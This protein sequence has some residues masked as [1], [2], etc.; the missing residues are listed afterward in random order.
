M[1][2]KQYQQFSP[3]YLSV[4]RAFQSMLSVGRMLLN[5]CMLLNTLLKELVP[6][7]EDK[8]ENAHSADHP[9]TCIKF[10]GRFIPYS[11]KVDK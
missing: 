2:C 1:Y 10:S 4:Y 8:K 11:Q 7:T 6:V 5:L 9:N 3:I